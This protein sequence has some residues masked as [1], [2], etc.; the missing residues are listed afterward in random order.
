MTDLNEKDVARLLEGAGQLVARTVDI[1][2]KDLERIESLLKQASSELTDSF[3][4]IEKTVETY[5]HHLD[6]ARELLAKVVDSGEDL[7]PA[8]LDLV[9]ELEAASAAGV[10]VE[11]HSS[12][13]MRALQFE[14]ITTQI[15]SATL[16]RFGRL[17]ENMEAV[18]AR[19]GDNVDAI[20]ETL[21][22]MAA[23]DQLHVHTPNQEDLSPSDGLLF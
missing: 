13:V 12:V 11:Q 4:T 8:L 6:S 18:V 19:H 3:L 10:T 2:L 9:E 22:K 23:D 5:G 17:S 20:V 16:A 7:P 15:L 1:G 14:D 21:E